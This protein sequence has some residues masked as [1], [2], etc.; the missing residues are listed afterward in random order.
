MSGGVETTRGHLW[1][2]I[3][4]PESTAQAAEEKRLAKSMKEY[5][6]SLWQEC[7]N[8]YMLAFNLQNVWKWR[9]EDLNKAL[10]TWNPFG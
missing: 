7:Q 6:Y 8:C 1:F 5:E 9:R 2:G 4:V 10:K 3:I